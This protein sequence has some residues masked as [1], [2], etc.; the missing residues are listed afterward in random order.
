[1]KSKHYVVAALLIFSLTVAM[2]YEGASVDLLVQSAVNDMYRKR[3]TQAY[4]LLK[5]AYKKDPYSYSVH[6]NLGRLFEETGN[7]NEAQKEYNIAVSINP[8]LVAAQRA[9]ARVSKQ[10]VANLQSQAVSKVPVQTEKTAAQ[11]FSDKAPPSLQKAPS[12]PVIP[13]RTPAPKYVKPEP[14]PIELAQIALDA[15]R[16]QETLERLEKLNAAEKNS[17]EYF[18]L[19]GK[20]HSAK[21]DLFKA[22]ISLEKAIKLKDKSLEARYL[23]GQNYQKAGLNEEALRHYMFYFNNEPQAFV[24]VEI[25]NLLEANGNIKDAK[26]YYKKAGELEPANA[27]IEYK[28]QESAV[29]NAQEMY[30]E[31]NKALDLH[32]YEE[33]YSLFEKALK[34]NTLGETARADAIRKQNIAL[35][36]QKDRDWRRRE[37]TQGQQTTLQ[38]YG[39]QNFKFYD[40]ENR[41]FLD[42]FTAP[43]TIEWQAYVAKKISMRGRHFMLMLKVLDR[44]ELDTMKVHSNDYKLNKYYSNKGAFLLMAPKDEFPGFMREGIVVVFTGTVNWQSFDVLNEAATTVSLPAIDFISAYPIDRNPNPL[45]HN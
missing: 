9:S 4:E 29:A 45:R 2:A 31:A 7:L 18:F 8:S 44:D 32:Q 43:V 30:L 21:G 25:G 35:F 26:E 19:Q 33:A 20:A 38:V 11:I 27:L 40:L 1:M 24:A 16:P 12:I 36:R 37:A 13:Q 6:F 34:T 5:E 15:G 14:T 41:T 3:Y 42:D 10:I 23:L 28:V 17:Y 22:I 39:N